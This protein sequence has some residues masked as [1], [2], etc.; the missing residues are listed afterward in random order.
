MDRLEQHYPD[1]C[2]DDLCENMTLIGVQLDGRRLLPFV[3]QTLKEVTSNS[4]FGNDETYRLVRAIISLLYSNAPQLA[5]DVLD[6]DA[7][8]LLQRYEFESLIHRA[9]W[10]ESATIEAWLTGVIKNGSM[11]AAARTIA[12]GVLL[13]RARCSRNV[14]MV[15]NCAD[16]FVREPTIRQSEGS[17]GLERLIG[18][19]AAQDPTMRVAL[20]D[21]AGETHS[22][23][24]AYG[25]LRIIPQIGGV[26]M[27]RG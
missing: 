3:R 8:S 19:I 17:Y 1:E 4:R 6:K 23:E 26:S 16:W 18:E 13:Q 22:L 7:R 20:L 14:E 10:V 25:W 27:L 9:Q 12:A 11:P 21:K 2:W 24:A 5:F 15:V